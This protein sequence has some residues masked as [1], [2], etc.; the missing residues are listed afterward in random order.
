M[1]GNKKKTRKVS[2][3]LL[4]EKFR[5]ETRSVPTKEHMKVAEEEGQSEE[6]SLEESTWVRRSEPNTRR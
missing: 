2:H 3:F 1:A 5:E 4:R 6:R